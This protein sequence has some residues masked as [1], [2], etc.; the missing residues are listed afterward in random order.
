VI[1]I[2]RYEVYRKVSGLGKKKKG[3]KEKKRN[4]DITYS[5]LDTISFKIGSLSI[6]E[7]YSNP[8][9]FTRFRNTAEVIFRNAVE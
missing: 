9:V 7:V 3:R 5:V 6:Y 4:V 8:I 1:F 2:L